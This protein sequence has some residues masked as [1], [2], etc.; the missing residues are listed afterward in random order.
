MSSSAAVRKTVSVVFCDLAG[1]TALG[2]QLDPESLRRVMGSWFDAMREPLERHGGTVEKFIGDA[3]MAVFGVPQAHEDDALRAVRAALEMREAVA[4]MSA[5]LTAQGRPPLHVRIGVNTGEVVT[6]DGDGDGTLVTGDAVNTAK[7]LEQAAGPDEILIG[8][9]TRRLV[10]NATRLEPTEPL[11]AKGKRLPVEAWR[12]LAAIEGAPPFSRRVDAPFVGRR[13]ELALLRRELTAAAEERSCRLVTVIGAAGIGKSR[14]ASELTDAIGADAAVLETRCLPY[15]DGITFLPLLDLFRSA[16]G[17]DA[18]AAAVAGEPDRVLILE[19]L[20]ALTGDTEPASPEET[21]WAVRRLLEALARDRPLLVRLDDI[22]WAEPTLLDLVEYIAGWSRGAPI[23]L[24]C[25]ARPELLDERPGWLHVPG[26]T[27][28]VAPLSEDESEE[29]LGGLEAPLEPDARARIREA[30]EGNPLFVEQMAAMLA[31]DPGETSMPATIHALLTARLDRLDPLERRILERASVLG[32]EFARGGVLALSP[33][34][35]RAVAGSALLALARRELIEPGRTPVPGD[36]GFRFRHALIRDAAY[37]GIPKQVRADLHERAGALIE[38]Q[39]DADELVGYHF[40]QAV[41]YREELG[42]ADSFTRTLAARAG[43]LLGEAGRRAFAHEDMPAAMNLLERALRL[44]DPSD[45]SRL[46]LERELSRAL[47]W[48]GEV[49]RADALLADLIEAATAAGD[50]RQRWYGLVERAS[51]R[52]VAVGGDAEVDALLGTAAEAIP[53]FESLGD[54]AGLA[55]AW[56][57]ISIAHQ[58]RLRYGAGEEA[59][60]R[61]LAHARSAAERQEEGRA[62]DSLCTCLLYGPTPADEAIVRCEEMLEQARDSR[63]VEANVSISLAGLLAM[64][65]RFDEARALAARAEL[66]YDELGARLALAGWTQVAGPLELLAGDPA[67]AER[68]LRH[69]YELL[70][71]VGEQGYQAL[72]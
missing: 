4:A 67:A 13:G 49:A 9:A 2:E 62:V 66:T 40:E 47:W 61:A 19:R 64:V 44:S 17:D 72:L 26:T 45:P 70:D 59:A 8:A 27:M 68:H 7:R 24:V 28:T 41:R 16:G 57:R 15:G 3:V 1:S 63:I 21:F 14:L 36:D 10:E 22:H 35:D 55:R 48:S 12:V 56:G 51:R 37:A 30:A 31:E 60:A 58:L 46:E 34:D 65:G 18:L 71:G 69:G 11:E 5:A 20:A 53:V 50:S 32:K 39:G 38:R 42:V 33:E 25:L 43:A 6:G 54:E 29:L 52:T 23:L